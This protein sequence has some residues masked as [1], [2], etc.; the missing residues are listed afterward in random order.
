[1]PHGPLQVLGTPPARAK[2]RLDV[3]IANHVEAVKQYAQLLERQ[4]RRAPVSGA[5]IAAAVRRMAAT[6][7]AL[8]AYRLKNPE[9]SKGAAGRG[10]AAPRGARGEAATAVKRQPADPAKK[11]AARRPITV[12]MSTHASRRNQEAIH[13]R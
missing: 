6:M 4:A 13:G 10:P 9:A 12:L 3:L 5:R 8:Q 2:S 7:R 11:K 1:V